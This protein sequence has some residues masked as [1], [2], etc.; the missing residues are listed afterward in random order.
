M[1]KTIETETNSLATRDA[2][3][4]GKSA[5]VGSVVYLIIWA[6]QKYITKS[7]LPTE[8]HAALSYILGDLVRRFLEKGKIVVVPNKY[9]SVKATAEKITKAL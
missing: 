6:F 7:E 1:A 4:V 5:L 9:E 8:I 2:K 3:Q